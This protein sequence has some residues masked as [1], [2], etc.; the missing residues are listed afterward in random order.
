[1]KN[2]LIG[3]LV[4]GSTLSSYASDLDCKELS[5]KAVLA[6]GK[7]NAGPKMTFDS[8]KQLSVKKT[9]YDTKTYVFEVYLQ[10]SNTDLRDGYKVTAQTFSGGKG[11]LVNKVVMFQYE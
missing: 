5:Q 7:V 6:L 4:F 9:E 1:M 11:C 8:I 2:F 3:F 10:D